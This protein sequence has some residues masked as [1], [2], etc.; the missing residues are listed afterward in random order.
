LYITLIAAV[1]A[2][3]GL[4]FGFDTGVIAGAML[5]IVPEF[6]LGPAQQGL[7]VSAVTFGA[8][9][10]SLVG[11][12]ASDKIGRRWTNIVAGMSFI[13]GS[14]LSAIAPNVDA[15]IASRVIIGLAI[16]L[17]SVA[18]PMYIAELSPAGSRG[19]LVSLFQLAVTAGIL[20][21]YIVDR[22]L[23]PEHAWRWM[24]GLAFVPGALLVLGMIA[25]P[26]SPRWLLKTGAEKPRAGRFRLCGYRTKSTAKYGKYGMTSST[27][28]RRR[29]LNC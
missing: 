28:G 12:I 3:G 14:V 25:M 27:I 18:A 21:S 17:T 16:G 9:L 4:L 15:L 29:G 7:V 2:L 22:T 10:G 8:L 20:V 26:E 19:K 5:F 1:A 11:G 6:H 13:A 23:A 24:L